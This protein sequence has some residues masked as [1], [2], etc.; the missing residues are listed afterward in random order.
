MPLNLSFIIA[1]RIALNKQ[2]SF[3]KFIIRLS[4]VATS[5][6][7]AAMIITLS[8]VNGFQETITQ[9]VFSFWGH[10]RVQHYSVNKSLVSEE[11]PITSNKTI[12]Q[13]IKANPHVKQVQVFA[14]KSAV[15]EKNKSIEGILIKG[16]DHLYDSSTI[17][18]FIKEG[19]WINF[20][21]SSYSKEI[22][23]S[24]T[25]SKTLNIQLNDLV[26]VF[27]VESESENSTYRPVKVVGIYKTGIEEYDNLFAIADIRLIR[28]LSNWQNNEIGGY[29][30][31]VDDYKNMQLVNNNLDLPNIWN[32]KTIQEVYPNIFDWLSIQ[33][34]NR[35]VM[36]IIMAIVAI[37]NLITCLLILVLERIKMVG[38]L[39]ALGCNNQTIQ[40]IFL[41]HA[42]IIAL[43]GIGIGLIVGVGLCLIQK[44]FGII[45]L[46]E[47][48]YYVAIAPVSIIWWQVILVCVSTAFIC[49]AALTI[50][51]LIVK[52][53]QPVKAIQ[54][55]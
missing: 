26:K 48:S 12:E 7:V 4:V 34:V 10:I 15:I 46:D 11:N 31:F 39:K 19:R 2:K 24:S 47:T 49:F 20:N 32:S 44:Y 30:V 52:R 17:K 13:T 9:K 55:R 50:P 21:D 22:I 5:L 29:E 54:F 14:T 18:Q 16:I 45:T 35:N 23:I 28:R 37:I 25:I 1:K 42:S 40:K 33:D 51:A 6:S 3:S 53:I 8:F 43:I 36:F 41:Y 27:F 38:I